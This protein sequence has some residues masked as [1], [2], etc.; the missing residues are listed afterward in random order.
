MIALARGAKLGRYV[1]LHGLG[2]GG[3]GR[4]YAAYDP[5]LDRS[6]ALKVLR[7]DRMMRG[8]DAE[9]LRREAQAIA[10]LDHPNVVSVFD[11]GVA[12]GR[13]FVAMER[14]HGQSLDVWLRAA[15][16]QPAEILDVFVQAGRG[17]AASHDAGIVHRDVKPSNVMI[18]REGRARVLDFGLAREGH[19][20]HDPS[21]RPERTSLQGGHLTHTGAA[22]GT[23]AYM[24]PEQRLGL[25]V[26][27]EADQWAY[28][29]ALW[30]AL[31]GSLPKPGSDDDL[32]LPTGVPAPVVRVLRRGL[33]TDPSSRWPSM[34][35]LVERLEQAGRR[36]SRVW[37]AAAVVVAL[38]GGSALGLGVAYD[39]APAPSCPD[40]EARSSRVWSSS[41]RDAIAGAV[42][43]HPSNQDVWRR[44]AGNLDRWTDRWNAAHREACR[45]THVRGEQSPMMLDRRLACLDEALAEVEA[46]VTWLRASPDSGLDAGPLTDALPD[47]GR[48]SDRRRLLDDLAPPPSGAVAS[49]TD[50]VRTMLRAA[51]VRERAGRWAESLA[52]AR[53]ALARATTVG[54]PPVEAEAHVRMAQ[55]LGR[56]GRFEAMRTH[57]LEAIRLGQAHHHDE[58]V[59]EAST[60]AIVAAL[61]LGRAAEGG[62]WASVSAGAI[63]RLRGDARSL[64]ARR[65]LFLGMLADATR[66]YE[67][68]I[69]H[70]EKAQRL[71]PD[72]PALDRAAVHNN[73]GVATKRLGR[74]DEARE[75]Y[76]GAL[77]LVAQAVGPHHPVYGSALYNL[78]RLE[79]LR[80]DPRAALP[81]LEAA[82]QVV[83]AAGMAGAEVAVFQVG[84]GSALLADGR[85]NEARPLLEKAVATF[86]AGDA[87]ADRLADGRFQLAKT[88]AVD[89]D[90]RRA[91]RLA[92]A[93]VVAW[94]RLGDRFEADREAAESWLAAM[95]SS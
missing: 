24:A 20:N 68:A 72:A 9:R 31:F 66:D 18:D 29:A 12:D 48:C 26:G 46:T 80:G 93:A 62:L 75:H 94:T 83:E 38:L 63:D 50:E 56:A 54:Y 5:E 79:L 15:R 30:E 55:P 57:L 22:I 67:S 11:V 73:L 43:K 8:D 3:M 2:G 64:A 36:R 51:A 1:V 59:A 70:Y 95:G 6:I 37:T 45:A 23:P 88:L 25:P 28:C 60:V 86:E 10:R 91:R 77:D 84:L 41:H 89:G 74:L 44:A 76:R 47:L 35:S 27:P 49:A 21:H 39:R 40:P 52:L 82:L 32:P 33:A 7:P 69:D 16:R 4:V 87:S 85:A 92:H 17:L 65:S 19:E 42:A 71:H 78:G 58:V 90:V 61:R 81:R 53:T 13:P 14:V 34:G